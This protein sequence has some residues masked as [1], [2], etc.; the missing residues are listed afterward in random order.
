MNFTDPLDHILGQPS[1]IRILRFLILT[2]VPMNG[3]EIGKAIGVSHVQ[4]HA[5]LKGLAEQGVVSMRPVG[6]ANLYELQ[7]DHIV[8]R[9]W[10]KP[11]LIQE[12]SLKESLAKTV[13][14]SLSSRPLSLILFGSIARR[15]D[16]PGSDIELIIV[17]PDRSDRKKFRSELEN[18]AEKVTLGY[19]NRL[20]PILLGQT[21]FIKALKHRDAFPGNALKQA[22]VIFGYSLPE[23]IAHR[24][25]PA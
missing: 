18:A 14:E 12:K 7:Q 11:L 6:R 15:E 4:C 16:R 1:K 13:V 24:R 2:G 19:G 21:E 9:D 17:M 22:E 10:L 25:L 23:L 20:S 5:A 8:V 3:R